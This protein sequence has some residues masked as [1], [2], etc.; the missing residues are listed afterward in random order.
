MFVRPSNGRCPAEVFLE[1]LDFKF[2]KKFKGAFQG[3][4]GMGAET[5]NFQRFKALSGK[6]K[7]L[8]EFKEFDHRLY[9]YRHPVEK[10]VRIVLFNGWVKD[11]NEGGLREEREI[12]KALTL[13]NEFKVEEGGVR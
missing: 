10:K 12:E 8:W 5:E 3:L 13:F 4:V 1:A 2:K 9:C 6:G 7:P 11:K